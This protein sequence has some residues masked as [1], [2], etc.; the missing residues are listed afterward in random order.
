MAI[1]WK[2]PIIFGVIV[3]LVL[4]LFLFIH[5]KLFCKKEDK[6]GFSVYLKL[7][8]AGLLASGGMAWLLFNRD[9]RFSSSA[10][11]VI[12]HKGGALDVDEV[13]NHVAPDVKSA[14]AAIVEKIKGLKRCHADEPNWD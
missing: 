7:F 13:A 4:C 5:D 6:S 11:S 14:P 3:G 1:N 10:S 9:I 8:M 2:N 12:E